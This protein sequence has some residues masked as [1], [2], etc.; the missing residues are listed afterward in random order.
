MKIKKYKVK[1]VKE[2]LI[3]SNA[4]EGVYGAKPYKDAL[5]AWNFLSKQKIITPAVILRVHKLLM[6]NL[7]PDIAGFWRHCDVFIGGQKKKFYSVQTIEF[8]MKIFCMAGIIGTMAL[9]DLERFAKDEH[10]KFEDLHPFED[11]NGRVGRLLYLW[12]RLNLDLPIHIIH[13]DYDED[14]SEQRE[15]YKWF[16]KDSLDKC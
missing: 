16:R 12:R 11:G 15:Y 10:I 1:D 3:Q 5:T 8:D 14:E 6:K 9:E 13:A 7:R 4:I 2:F